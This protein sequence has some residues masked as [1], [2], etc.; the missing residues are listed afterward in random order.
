MPTHLVGNVS[1][2]HREKLHETL[3]VSVKQLLSVGMHCRDHLWKSQSV[4]EQPSS[5]LGLKSKADLRKV[6]QGHFIRVWVKHQVELVEIAVYQAVLS[7]LD[8][9]PHALVENILPA[10]EKNNNMYLAAVEVRLRSRTEP[11]RTLGFSIIPL[12]SC[13]IGDAFGTSDMRTTWRFWSSGTGV[14]KS[15]AYSARINAY[16]LVADSLWRAHAL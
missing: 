14:G 9:Q 8:A 2:L 16:S 12:R 1:L 6:D 10:N 11:Q 15:F 5:D 3:D 7:Q 13:A 4:S